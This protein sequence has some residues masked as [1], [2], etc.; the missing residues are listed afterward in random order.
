MS[1]LLG[2]REGLFPMSEALQLQK[3]VQSGARNL[4]ASELLVHRVAP[5]CLELLQELALYKAMINR[6]MYMEGA[7]QKPN[8]VSTLHP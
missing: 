3:P 5:P 4:E 8:T 7:T 2:P 6:G 1:L